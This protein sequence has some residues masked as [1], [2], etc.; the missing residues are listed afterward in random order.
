MGYIPIPHKMKTKM[1]NI[2]VKV[3]EWVGRGHLRLLAMDNNKNVIGE[4]PQAVPA[5]NFTKCE[6]AFYPTLFLCEVES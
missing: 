1:K 5:N 3:V 4:M 2:I 6:Y